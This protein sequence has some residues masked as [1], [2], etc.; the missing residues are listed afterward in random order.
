MSSAE[1]VPRGRAWAALALRSLHGH[2]LKSFFFFHLS[3]EDQTKQISQK[4]D[5]WTFSVQN[6]QYKIHIY[7]MIQINMQYL[8]NCVA[9]LKCLDSKWPMDVLDKRKR[10]LEYRLFNLMTK[11]TLWC[12]LQLL[13][14]TRKI[15]MPETPLTKIILIWAFRKKNP[16]HK[17]SVQVT[18]MLQTH[19]Y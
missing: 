2:L 1:R 19:N 11:Y 6:L 4:Q 18:F 16:L 3:C 12:L 7:N 14:Q 17:T 5:S 9:H 13:G 8:N 10:S 15:I